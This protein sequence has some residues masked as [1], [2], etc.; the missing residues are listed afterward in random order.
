M[1]PEVNF[2]KLTNCVGWENVAQLSDVVVVFS[3]V[4]FYCKII[5]Y[6]N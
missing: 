2:M 1:F 5:R 6:E 4:G 3:F